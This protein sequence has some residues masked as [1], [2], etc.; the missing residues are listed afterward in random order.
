MRATYNKK[1]TNIPVLIIAILILSIPFLRYYDVVFTDISLETTIVFFVAIISLIYLFA[2]KRNRVSETSKRSIAFLLLFFIYFVLITLFSVVIRGFQTESLNALLFCFATGI[3]MISFFYLPF[4][5]EKVI[6]L[7]EFLVWAV[8][9]IYLFQLLLSLFGVKI[10]FKMPLHDF[11]NSWSKL[12]TY[13]FGMNDSIPT[14]IFAER[15]HF[16]EYI[17]PYICLCIFSKNFIRRR[18]A[19]AILVSVVAISTVS[20]N[21]VVLVAIV[22]LIYFLFFANVKKANKVPL[23]LVGITLLFFSYLIMRKIPAFDKMFNTLFVNSTGFS[24]WTKADFR[25]YR[26]FDF[27]ARM[28]ISDKFFGIGYRTISFYSSSIRITSIYDSDSLYSYLSG[29]T[30]VL[31]YFGVFGF[32]FFKKLFKHCF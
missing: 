8:I 5:K 2:N 12:S 6:K 11:S 1:I 19:K 30:Q 27:F 20:G 13:C 14:S 17:I 3:I 26:G 7:Y 32:F 25:I 24:S 16:C 4:Q 9:S 28:P 22:W 10:N 18:F 31:I 29:I 23:L 15:A 21:G